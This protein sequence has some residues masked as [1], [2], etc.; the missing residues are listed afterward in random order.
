[1][2]VPPI[3]GLIADKI[4]NFRLLI[5]IITFLNGA[6]SLL[7]LTMGSFSTTDVYNNQSIELCCLENEEVCF[8]SNYLLD[9]KTNVDF[10]MTCSSQQGQIFNPTISRSLYD[11]TCLTLNCTLS[12]SN[13]E[14]V[15]DQNMKMK[16][17]WHYLSI[18]GVSISKFFLRSRLRLRVIGQ[19]AEVKPSLFIDTHHSRS[20]SSSPN[21][22][23]IIIINSDSH[24]FCCGC[25]GGRR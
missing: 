8:D 14:N 7:L 6:A 20:R 11:Q 23:H 12:Q 9:N 17:F 16:L 5:A 2:I 10:N 4:G 18:R 22:P 19:T 13:F 1:M 25:G 3:S 24:S 15:T 21:T